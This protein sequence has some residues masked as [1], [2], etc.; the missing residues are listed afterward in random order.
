[1]WAPA[2]YVA[3][4]LFFFLFLFC[5]LFQ[6]LLA[7]HPS[8]LTPVQRRPSLPFLFFWFRCAFLFFSSL[9]PADRP[10]SLNR[11]LHGD[12]LSPASVSGAWSPFPPRFPAR[13]ALSLANMKGEAASRRPRPFVASP[14][15]PSHRIALA[16]ALSSRRICHPLSY[17]PS[18]SSPLHRAPPPVVSP[19]CAAVASLLPPL[20]SLLAGLPR[21]LG[22]AALE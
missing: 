13:R 21:L 12:P 17:R 15:S 5:F 6:K 16:F 19:C 9:V 1:M 22:F 18:P 4:F 11:Y 20:A 3:S 2:W 8:L 10:P 7:L 14:S